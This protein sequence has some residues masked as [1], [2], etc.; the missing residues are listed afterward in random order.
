MLCQFS[1]K[2]Y[3]SYKNETTFDLQAEN[4]SEFKDSI[5]PFEEVSNLLPI[6]VIY[7]PN[8]GGKTNLLQALS[9]LIS[10]VTKPIEDLKKN[11]IPFIIQQVPSCIPFAMDSNSKNEPT[12]FNIFFRVK[13]N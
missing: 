6:S 4:L 9:C 5:I 7:G 3:L 1:F 11:R 10:T 13:E 12:E 8:G 2:N